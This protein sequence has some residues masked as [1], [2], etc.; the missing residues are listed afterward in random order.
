[1]ALVEVG[2]EASFQDVKGSSD[3]G[4]SCAAGTI[5]QSVRMAELQ[6]MVQK[7]EEA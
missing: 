2:L 1:L 4:C 3:N 7:T 6:A 5:N